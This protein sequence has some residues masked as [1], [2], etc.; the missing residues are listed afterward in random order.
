MRIHLS[1]NAATCCAMLC[2]TDAH[3]LFHIYLWSYGSH[4][5]KH[6]NIRKTISSAIQ[7]A[8]DD[9]V[10]LEKTE[11]NSEDHNTY[12]VDSV[13]DFVLRKQ[14]DLS[15]IGAILK[16]CYNAVRVIPSPVIH[17]AINELILGTIDVRQSLRNFTNNAHSA[18]NTFPF[19]QHMKEAYLFLSSLQSLVFQRRQEDL[20]YL[21]DN[22]LTR[23][24]SL[25]RLL[26]TIRRPSLDMLSS[27][28]VGLVLPSLLPS[29][30]SV[31]QFIENFRAVRPYASLPE[32]LCDFL[33]SL[34]KRIPADLI[35][36]HLLRFLD[37]SFQHSIGQLDIT[38]A[39]GK[40]NLSHSLFS[41]LYSRSC[42]EYCIV[43]L[44]SFMTMQLCR[45]SNVPIVPNSSAL[46]VTSV[47]VFFASLL[48]QDNA[49]GPSICCRYTVPDLVLNICS[50]TKQNPIAQALKS[51]LP[52]LPEDAI[53][54]LIC[55]PILRNIFPSHLPYFCA[56]RGG[57]VGGAQSHDPNIVPKSYYF[58]DE[59]VVLL[60]SC[61][62]HLD[63][64]NLVKYFF[65][66][67]SGKIE[68]STIIC[69]D[70]SEEF[71]DLANHTLTFLFKLRNNHSNPSCFT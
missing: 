69:F 68:F 27:A 28:S 38:E 11:D 47:A 63:S 54:V 22:D 37:L 3:Y 7:T 2:D 31:D 16:E 25:E 51:L 26:A 18:E 1:F 59:L 46:Q 13:T 21:D 19:P 58:L 24:T 42:G 34:S 45:C 41:S 67:N 44:T 10:V 32:K 33:S 36:P 43:W 62:R 70:A 29:V 6:S 17:T 60:R 8:L 14:R 52:F 12:S 20:M 5:K 15:M 35:V 40:I 53:G 64:E 66:T 57:K 71:V 55:K 9:H 49:L 56:T 23:S 39:F 48:A 30:C 4:P 50:N 65:S 61:L